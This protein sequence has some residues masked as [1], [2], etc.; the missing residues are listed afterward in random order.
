MKQAPDIFMMRIEQE[1]FLRMFQRP[2]SFDERRPFEPYLMCSVINAA[3]NAC[4]D[5]QKSISLD[6]NLERVERLIAQA[7][8]VESQVEYVQIK[9]E[10]L[11]ALGKLPPRQ[12]AAIV[13]R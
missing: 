2:N 11:D 10:L 4:L 5:E 3:L 7:V 13:Q 6:G 12:R 8:S 9:S 1:V